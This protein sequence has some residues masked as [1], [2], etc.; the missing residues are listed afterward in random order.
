MLA[1]MPTMKMIL[2]RADIMRDNMDKQRNMDNLDLLYL[3][4]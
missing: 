4:S 2:V 1:G 3:S